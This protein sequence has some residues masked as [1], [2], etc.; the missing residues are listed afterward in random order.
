M[1]QM[2][3]GELAKF[4]GKLGTWQL[5]AGRTLQMLVEPEQEQPRVFNLF[6]SHHLPPLLLKKNWPKKPKKQR[7]IK[8]SESRKRRRTQRRKKKRKK[9]KKQLKQS[10]LKLLTQ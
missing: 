10:L 7:R 3:V 6:P 1:T 5:F 4:S 2:D 9:L 8:S